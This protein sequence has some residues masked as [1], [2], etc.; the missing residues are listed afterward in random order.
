MSSPVSS[1]DDSSKSSGPGGRLG[2]FDLVRGLSVV[3]M[4]LFHLCY[5]LKF[6]SGVELAWFEPPLQD[7]WRCSISWSFLFIAGCMCALSRN[8]LRRALEYG[9]VALAVWVVTTVAA[10]DTPISFGIIYCMSACTL[11]AWVL[12]RIGA[13]PRGRVAA[14]VLFV[15]FVALLG[16]SDG[17][18]GIGDFALR[19]P[20]EVASAEGLAWLGIPSSSFASGDYYP[21]LPYLLIYLSGAAMGVRWRDRGYPAWAYEAKVA[22][23]NFVGRHALL[24]YVVHQPVILGMCALL[25]T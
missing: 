23:L 12:Q 19:L 20:R 24:V 6:L 1:D 5:D 21:L 8:N 4:V 15:G 11:V 25:G 16:L 9:G 3:S 10:V 17:T 13:L 22:P 14:C 7:I 18:I 2:I